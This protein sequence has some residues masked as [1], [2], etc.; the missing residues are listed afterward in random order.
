M[1]NSRPFHDFLHE[2]RQGVTQDELSDALQELVAAVHDTEKSGSLTFT[3]TI[4]PT[5]SG[6]LEVSDA[7]RT[8]IPTLPKSSSLFFVSPENNLVRDDPKQH[9]LNLQEIHIHQEAR[10]IAPATAAKALA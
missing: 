7:I 2:H 8:K 1:A 4:K 6:A 10:P 5:K 3:I 9:R